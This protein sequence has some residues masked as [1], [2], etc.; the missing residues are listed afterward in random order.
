VSHIGIGLRVRCPAGD[1]VLADS[2]LLHYIAQMGSHSSPAHGF[3][4]QPDC[5]IHGWHEVF[6]GDGA[7]YMGSRDLVIEVRPV[8][9]PDYVPGDEEVDAAQAEF[10]KRMQYAPK[11][12]VNEVHVAAGNGRCICGAWPA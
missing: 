6:P 11:Q 8:S 7:G 1:L 4:C 3:T 2:D 9:L 5:G 10:A 12:C